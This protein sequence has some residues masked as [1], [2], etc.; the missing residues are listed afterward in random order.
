MPT[1]EPSRRLKIEPI[2]RRQL[3]WRTIDVE[4]LVSDDDA[5]RAIWD[6]SGRLDL[7]QFYA[8]VVSEQ[9]QAGREAIDPRLL[10]CL[11]VYAYSQG[12]SSARE[13]A[14]LCDYHPGFQWL[15]GVRPINHHTLSDFR[16]DHG[17]ALDELFTQMLALLTSEGL[18]SLERVMQDGT[19]IKANAGSDSFRREDR[20]KEHLRLA[21]EQVDHLK[22]QTEEVT[23]RLEAARSRAARERTE[24]LEQALVALDR[25]KAQ[26]HTKKETLRASTSDPEC[27]I[28]KHGGGGGYG[29]SYNLQLTTDAKAGAIAHVYVTPH[30]VDAQELEPAMERLKARLGQKPR[31]VVADAQYTTNPTVLKMH[32]AKIDF[33]GA[34]KPAKTGIP[35]ALARR[36]IDPAFGPDAFRYESGPDLFRCPAG[37]VLAREREHNAHFHHEVY[38]RASTADCAGCAFKSQCSPQHSARA[39]IRSQLD[40]VIAAFRSRMQTDEAK[41]IY[42][43]R[44]P[45]AE[46]PNAWLKDKLDLRRFRMRGLVKV[47]L[48]ALWASLTYNIQLWIRR[49]WRPLQAA[50]P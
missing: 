31:Q 6:V 21:R 27:R 39:V 44:G 36:G 25:M 46:F 14:R 34:L 28:M 45:I 11:W 32:K 2:D 49:V 10:I 19:K 12:I 42:K 4:H 15:T 40:P 48:E 29:P 35:G 50:T 38:Y 23:P 16:A 3:Q 22:N 43:Q 18:L 17:S 20:L 24:R 37:K 26:P 9:G 13:I 47:T 33:I 8:V 5:V 41:A 7:Q 1:P 30:V